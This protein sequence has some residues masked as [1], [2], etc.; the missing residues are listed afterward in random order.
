MLSTCEFLAFENQEN[1][2]NNLAYITDDLSDN[3]AFVLSYDSIVLL[4]H[5]RIDLGLLDGMKLVC[6]KTVKNQLNNDINEELSALSSDRN[7]GSMSYS[8]GGIR[9]IEYTPESRRIRHTYLNDLKSFL[10]KIKTVDSDYDYS[11]HNQTWKEPFTKLIL[12]SKLLC[13]SSSLGLAQNIDNAILITDDQIIYN[14]ASVESIKNI[15]I[16]G[17][18]T[19]A[20]S[21]WEKLL[22]VSK[23]LQRINFLNYLPI[24]LYQRIVDSITEDTMHSQ[25]GNEKTIEWLLSDTDGIPTQHHDH[26]V[27]ALFREIITNQ[28]LLY[29]YSDPIR[30]IALKAFDRQNPGFIAKQIKS[31]LSELKISPIEDIEEQSDN[32]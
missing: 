5:L 32:E 13:E 12:E 26:I 18:L 23:A 9:F 27:I 16:E 21:R 29:L 11:P 24:F 6:S 22:E 15:G 25:E 8:D 1:I 20:D 28:E 19:L 10:G 14:I 30:A 2:R 3:S 4:S 7:F 17:L 31:A